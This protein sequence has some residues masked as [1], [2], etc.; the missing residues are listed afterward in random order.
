MPSKKEGQRP[1]LAVY[2]EEQEPYLMLQV[3]IG[4]AT[5]STN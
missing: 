2:S 1:L 4:L 3:T 5:L